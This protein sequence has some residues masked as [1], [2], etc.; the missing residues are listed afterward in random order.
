MRDAGVA[1]MATGGTIGQLMGGNRGPGAAIGG[2]LGAAGGLTSHLSAPRLAQMYLSPKLN[3]GLL[4]MNAIQQQL[5]GQGLGEA[6]MGLLAPA[7][8]STRSK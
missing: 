6:S 2:A 4:P 7:F 8:Q 5:L 1:G 3:S